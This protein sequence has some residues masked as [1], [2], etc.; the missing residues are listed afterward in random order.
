MMIVLIGLLSL[1]VVNSA[2]SYRIF[3]DIITNSS[4]L[5]RSYVP[6]EFVFSGTVAFSGLALLGLKGGKA[7][8]NGALVCLWVTALFVPA[9]HQVVRFFLN[10][11]PLDASITL[12]LLLLIPMTTYFLRSNVIAQWFG[13]RTRVGVQAD[14]SYWWFRARGRDPKPPSVFSD[15]D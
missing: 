15:F 1:V 2:L 6:W 13:Y 5:E 9:A 7:G 12:N 10:D 8:L 3:Q 14:A 11:E 4:A